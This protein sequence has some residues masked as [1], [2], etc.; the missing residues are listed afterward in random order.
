M[1]VADHA[2]HFFISYA[3]S[4]R[5]W[6]E[7]VGWHV[8]QAGHQVTLD[9]WDWRTGDNFVQRM[10]RAID[11]SDAVIALFSK[12]Y[13]E[14]ER[15]TTEEWTAAVARRDHLIPL[16]L[17]PITGQDL[18]PTLAAKLR[19]NLHGLDETDALTALREAVNG[20]ARPTDR[21][22]FPGTTSTP[23]TAVQADPTKPRLPNAARQPETWNVRRRNPDF[24][25]RETEIVRLRDGLLDG[26]KAAIQALHGM[27]GIGKTQLAL[28]YAH[29]FAGQYDL[30]WWI[31]AEQV[32][33]IS[34]SYSELAARRDIAKPDAGTEA[35]ARALLSHLATRDRW[36]LILDNVENPG[37]I[38]PWLPDGPGHTL[39]TSRNPHWVGTAHPTRLDVFT[40]TDSVTYLQSRIPGLGPEQADTLS[41]D[42]G[43]LPLAL[44]QCAGVIAG[45]VSLDHYRQ[46]LTTNTARILERGGAPGYPASLAATV[47]IATERL[48]DHHPDALALLHLGAFLG[49]EPIPTTW[50]ETA[51]P[52]L[53]TIPGDPTDPLWLHDALEPLIRYGLTRTDHQTF[54]IHR[55]TQAVLRDR[56]CL[57]QTSAIQNDLV[58]ILVA[59]SPGDPELPATWPQWAALTTHLIATLTALGDRAELR[60]TLLNASRYLV[61]SAQPHVA[62]ELAGQLHQRWMGALG[63]DHPDTWNAAFMQTWALDGLGDSKAALPLVEA[64]L[65]AR[66]RILGEDHPDTLASA[67]DLAVTLHALGRHEESHAM[68]EVTLE[69]RRRILGEDHPDT[70]HS[71][72]SLAVT[73]SD[74]GRHEE[75]RA[76]AE[77]TLAAQRRILGD[78]H[79]HTL[80]SAH[81]LATTLYALGRHEESLT[82]VE[83]TLAARRRIL[84]EDHPD[85]LHSAHDLGATLSALGRYEE[86]RAM[87]EVTLAARRRVLGEDHRD[88]FRS[89]HDLGA[90]LNDLGRYEESHAMAEVTLAARRR[91]LG[92]DHRD[93]LRSADGLAVTLHNLGRYEESRA[94]KEVT[95]AARRRVLGEDDRDTLRSAHGL[96]VT[97]YALGRHE[98][99]HA[100]VEAT[101]AAQRRILGEDHPDTLA[102]AHSLGVCLSNLRLHAEAVQILEDTLR[103]YRRTLGNDHPDTMRTIKILAAELTTMRRIFDAQRLLSGQPQKR[104]L[105]GRRK[106]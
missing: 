9:V 79:P 37:Q 30:V 88:T 28:E 52:D 97:L 42:L 54:Q 75:A 29:R 66:R 45:G 64:T 27:G 49:P 18:P 38:E 33:Q 22:P 102:S 13:F 11:Q 26:R 86:A 53:A 87:K 61:R 81:S 50:L 85:T 71:A 20:G 15:W 8:E 35:N 2:Q 74:L 41:T 47:T 31:D 67:H 55:L 84:G 72:H 77:A 17:E 10:D 43:D 12:S 90:T 56:A 82:M 101:L 4:D 23:S 70:L 96:A 19:K 44:A 93:T 62:H 105:F 94:M 5:L 69:A 92:E 59:A 3:G 36:L 16:A 57:E 6:A 99:S 63:E 89:A 40:R 21:P 106:K 48:T 39:I 7:W 104:R 103:R 76:M 14:D 95:L 32:D 58:A 46:L 24:S 25:G 83:A 60:P 80:T 100:M 65:A 51:R 1:T 68:K 98:E 73:L 78:D 34:V 91:V